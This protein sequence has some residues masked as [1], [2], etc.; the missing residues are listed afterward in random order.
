LN[1]DGTY[2]YVVDK[3]AAQ[4]LDSGETATDQFTYTVT[5]GTA[6]S[7][8]STLT[9][10]VFGNN[11]APVAV[12]DTNW[13]QEDRHACIDGNVILGANHSPDDTE[14][15]PPSG[16]FADAADTD[17]D[18]DPLTVA[19]VNGYASNVGVAICGR[20]GTLTL[21]ADGSY[22]YVVNDA[23]V[24]E[25]DGCDTV[26]DQFTYTVTDG[27]AAS[28]TATLTI[29]VFG[30]NDAPLAVSDTNW[31]QE[32]KHTCIDGNVI[33][34]AKHSPDNTEGNPPSG[35]FA[36]R[37]D[38]DADSETLTVNSVNGSGANVGAALC[39]TYG[40][41]TLNANGCYTYVV[42]SAAVQGLDSYETVTDQFTYT[43]T[44]GAATSNTATL[45]ITVFGS[46]DAPS[47]VNTQ[48]WMPSDSCQQTAATPRYPD[49]YPLL[50][51]IP[52]DVDGE[53]VTVT[54]TGAIP[55]GVFYFDGSCYVEL[56]CGTLLYDPSRSVNLLDDLVYRPTDCPS[57]VVNT[58]LEL[59]V[60][61]GTAHVTQTI[62]IHEAA[63]CEDPGI[64]VRGDHRLADQIYGTSGNDTLAGNGGDD[65]IDGRGGHDLICGGAG[66]DNFKFAACA[67]HAVI[68]D[69]TS[70]QDHLDLSS[71]VTTNDVN[72]WIATHVTACGQDTLIAVDDDLTITLQNVRPTSLSSSDF[73]VHPNGSFN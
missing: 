66:A 67:G 18:A 31:A 44:D 51:S 20:Y 59:D 63:P 42:N 40:T 4:R 43:V 9:I 52:T 34:G 29:T 32:E 30:N 26:T 65:I 50:V 17:A 27:A 15:H 53:N 70:G 10:T 37:A 35:A 61:D 3:L 24:Q 56:T 28:N 19:T 5:D 33:L 45:T 57:D 13:A 47:V 64:V 71:I 46:N 54:A 73:I 48:N 2:T 69:F 62:G 8:I 39:G 49:G 23:A 58:T 11:D 68:G 38:T 36:D 16:T 25:L 1:A 41:L 12:A 55:Q 72:A 60:F 6:T 22:S 14:G 21:N 7:N